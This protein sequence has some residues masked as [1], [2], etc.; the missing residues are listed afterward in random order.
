MRVA[1]PFK[2]S[3]RELGVPHPRE[4]FETYGNGVRRLR[5]R[6]KEW[7]MAS[8]LLHPVGSGRTVAGVSSREAKRHDVGAEGSAESGWWAWCHAQEGT[9]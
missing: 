7:R 6:D 1:L 5:R 9:W 3:A 2:G 4:L 8:S